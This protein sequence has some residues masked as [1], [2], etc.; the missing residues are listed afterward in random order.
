[1]SLDTYRRVLQELAS[2]RF[3]GRFSPYLMNEPLVDKRLPRLLAM[4]REILPAAVILIQTNGDLLTVEKGVHFFEAG[5]H[6]LI[7]NCYDDINHRISRL[8]EMAGEISGRVPGLKVAAKSSLAI[9]R[10]KQGHRSALEISVHD[11]TSRKPANSTNR[12]GNVPLVRVPKEP[13]KRSC[14][15]PFVQLFVRYNGDVVLCCNDWKGEVVFGNL[16]N[17]NLAS[18]YGCDLARKY[19]EKLAKKD[20]RMKLCEICD[21][22]G[23]S[24]KLQASFNR[25]VRRLGLSRL[26]F[27]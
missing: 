18:I 21:Y 20:R 7:I 4:A 1:M 24:G 11:Q 26:L 15:R 6:K 23:N 14:Y 12:A 27:K 9:I 16:N 17:E 22:H 2:I 13:L 10:S 19:R 25:S 8:R 3:D 5:L